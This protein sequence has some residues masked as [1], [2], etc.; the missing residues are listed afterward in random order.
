[1]P[2]AFPAPDVATAYRAPRV[3]AGRSRFV[4]VPPATDELVAYCARAFGWPPARVRDLLD[5]VL[6]A[7]ADRAS[8]ATLDH[9][10]TFRARFAKLRSQRLQRAVAGGWG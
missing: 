8:Q 2:T 7:A 6:A 4:Q 10:L 3:D 5:P 1:M 9:F